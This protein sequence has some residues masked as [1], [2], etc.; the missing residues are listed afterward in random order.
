MGEKEHSCQNFMSPNPAAAHVNDTAVL[1]LCSSHTSP[2][3]PPPPTNT[4]HMHTPFRAAVPSFLFSPD[5]S[6]FLLREPLRKERRFDWVSL[7][8]V[9][10]LL[11]AGSHAAI[12]C[13]MAVGSSPQGIS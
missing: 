5:S 11:P 13:H 12:M 8:T 9:V 10:S 1:T 2:H 7:S 4:F 6:P 3:A